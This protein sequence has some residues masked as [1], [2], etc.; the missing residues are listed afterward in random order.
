M[1]AF[2]D[3]TKELLVSLLNE[4]NEEVQRVHESETGQTLLDGRDVL[5]FSE[6]INMFRREKP[7][8]DMLDDTIE[9]PSITSRHRI[10]AVVRLSMFVYDD[11]SCEDNDEGSNYSSGDEGASSET[12]E[13]DSEP[14]VDF[15]MIQSNALRQLQKI[16]K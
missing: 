4:A 12:D 10:E 16:Y 13:Y 14:V 2:C 15:S 8:G 6:M 3:Q 7:R 5:P 11:E 9:G 1:C